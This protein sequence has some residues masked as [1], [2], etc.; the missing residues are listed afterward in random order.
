M[1][2]W[3]HLLRLLEPVMP[4]VLPTQKICHACRLHFN[5]DSLTDIAILFDVDPNTLSN[6]RKTQIWK[7]YEAKLLE[8][9]HQQQNEAEAQT[10]GFR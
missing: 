4:R 2:R 5:G 10:Q 3:V 9:W 8:E 7:D 6:W 1:Q